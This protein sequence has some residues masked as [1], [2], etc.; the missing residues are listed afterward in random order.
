MVEDIRQS[1]V[2]IIQQST[3]LS[4]STKIAAIRKIEHMQKLVGYPNDLEVPGAL[5]S[6]FDTVSL[7]KRTCI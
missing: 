5:D 1:F 6:Y 4:Q 3:W 2:E 7:L